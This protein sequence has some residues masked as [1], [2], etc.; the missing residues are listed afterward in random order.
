MARK[1]SAMSRNLRLK[2]LGT[3]GRMYTLR[4]ETTGHAVSRP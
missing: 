4:Y 2:R 1:R 3:P